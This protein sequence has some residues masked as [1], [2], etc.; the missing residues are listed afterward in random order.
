[1][2]EEFNVITTG[3]IV[4]IMSESVPDNNNDIRNHDDQ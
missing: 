3:E 4:F 2:W 1:M